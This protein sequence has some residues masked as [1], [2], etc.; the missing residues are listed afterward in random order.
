MPGA[1]KQNKFH[2]TLPRKLSLYGL[3]LEVLLLTVNLVFLS[4]AVVTVLARSHFI[5]QPIKKP[6][7]LIR[8]KN[9]DY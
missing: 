8:G 1:I 3:L 5:P 4:N 7:T 6:S 2:Y 9:E